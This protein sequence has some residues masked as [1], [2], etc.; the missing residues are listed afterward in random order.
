M[1][2]SLHGFHRCR[3]L[4]GKSFC[5]SYQ[6]RDHHSHGQCQNARHGNQRQNIRY[7]PFHR[8]KLLVLPKQIFLD[9]LHWHIHHKGNG[10]SQDKR[11]K[12]A[13]YTAHK[14]PHNIE[15]RNGTI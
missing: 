4:A 12:E 1:K 13:E 3:N 8:L 15:M 11:H 9:L 5:G 14:P 7:R 6:L 2:P 10:A